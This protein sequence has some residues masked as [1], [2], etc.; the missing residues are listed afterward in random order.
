MTDVS[1]SG[2]QENRISRLRRVQR[3]LQIAPCRHRD[4]RGPAL[5]AP[6]AKTSSTAALASRIKCMRTG[7]QFT[8]QRCTIPANSCIPTGV[9]PAVLCTL[10]AGASCRQPPLPDPNNEFPFWGGGRSRNGKVVGRQV[11]VSGWALDDA[12]VREIRIYVDSR[13]KM[14]AVL[15]IERPDVT[16][17]IR[18]MPLP[19]TCTAG[20]K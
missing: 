16:K 2:F 17:V 5:P 15:K 19:M 7:V 11:E 12:G 6:A 13:Y 3:G 14:S 1:R 18:N 10:M 8:R 9:W 20:G 4:R